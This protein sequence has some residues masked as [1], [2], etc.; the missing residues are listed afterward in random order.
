MLC[1]RVL[2]LVG[3]AKTATGFA[4]VGCPDG[5]YK[6]FMDN[7]GCPVVLGGQEPDSYVPEGCDALCDG[8]GAAAYCCANGFDSELTL[9]LYTPHS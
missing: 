7:G 2:L 4:T 6:G 1:L 8:A 5:C 9:A 3:L